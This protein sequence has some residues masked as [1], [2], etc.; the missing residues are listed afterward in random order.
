MGAPKGPLEVRTRRAGDRV[1]V[2]G[3]AQSL[4]RYLID[5]RVP[6]E[7][8]A[9]LPLVAAG[10]EVLWMPERPLSSAGERYL[11]VHLEPA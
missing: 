10:Q 3:R 2:R 9:G 5:Q 4:K 11:R 7:E 6:A 8:R 1:R